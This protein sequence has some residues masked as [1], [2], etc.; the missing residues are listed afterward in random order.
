MQSCG[1]IWIEKK[2]LMDFLR[3]SRDSQVSFSQTLRTT[4]LHVPWALNLGLYTCLFEG[5]QAFREEGRAVLRPQ[6]GKRSSLNQ[7]TA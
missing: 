6:G 2:N 3:G 1:D 4:A 7:S 5:I